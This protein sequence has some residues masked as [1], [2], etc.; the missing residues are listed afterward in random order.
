MKKQYLGKVP[1][2]AITNV[3]QHNITKDLIGKFKTTAS[4]HQY[5]FIVTDMLMNY[6]WF[7]PLFTKEAYEVL[8]NVYSK[9]GGSHKIL[10]DNVTEFKNKLFTQ[11][12]SALGMK[13]VLSSL[14][15]LEVL[16][17]LKM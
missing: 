11:I 8:V 10:P 14:L 4:E 16:D 13:Q 12:V 2:H 7:I 1:H 15:I 3:L 17:S 5:A 6:T 9:F